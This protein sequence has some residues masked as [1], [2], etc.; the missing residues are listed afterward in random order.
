MHSCGR[1]SKH[2][3]TKLHTLISADTLQGYVQASIVL[4]V[5]RVIVIIVIAPSSSAITVAVVTT[6]STPLFLPLLLQ[7]YVC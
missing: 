2:E 6:L 1:V 5:G 4:I 7:L 3:T